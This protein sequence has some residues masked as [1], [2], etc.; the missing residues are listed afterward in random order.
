[1]A[2]NVLGVVSRISMY[3]C[4]WWTLGIWKDRLWSRK[5]QWWNE[6]YTQAV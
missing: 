2:V 5:L 1:M 6:E 4:R 3:F